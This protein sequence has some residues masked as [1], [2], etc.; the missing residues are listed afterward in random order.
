MIICDPQD[1]SAVGE[2]PRMS[3]LDARSALG[4]AESARRTMI[5]LSAQ[6]RA[7]ILE[8]VA[9]R[10]VDNAETRAV[11]IAR[12]GV[13][14]ITEARLEVSRAINTL[15]LSSHA[16]LQMTGET[17][18]FQSHPNGV[19]RQGWWTPEPIGIVVAITPF[20]DPL[21]LV[22][23]KLGPAIAAGCPVVLK[24]HEATPLSAIALADDLRRAGLP[25]GALEIV[26]G[27]GATVGPPLVTDSRTALISFTGGLDTGRRIANSAGLTRMAMELGS[28][29][30]TIILA[31]AD[32]DVA[33]KAC[34][35][36]MISTAGQN[37]LHVQ[38][39]VCARE[40]A[41]TF[42]DRIAAGLESVRLGPK[43][44]ETT[45]MGCLISD[46]A[47]IRISQMVD[48]AIGNGARCLTGGIRDGTWMHPVLLDNV[49]ANDPLRRDE[50]FGPVAV[51]IEVDCFDE[52]IAISNETPFG[53]QAAIFTSNLANAH[54]AVRQLD[55]GAVL[56][57]E[58]TDYRLD[59]MPFGG[60]RHSGI[61]REG[62]ASAIASMSEPKVACFT[63]VAMA[64]GADNSLRRHS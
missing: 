29:C 26:T 56:V 51:L 62:V 30:P 43:C 63:N 23:H 64:K 36:G 22:A 10:L 50:V 54:A 42:R 55:A 9:S 25:K 46:A 1:G 11:L 15:R 44:D 17:I 7:S 48:N 37:C 8:S 41:D 61:G 13:K 34:L 24:P 4:R 33:A 45:Q 59:A 27:E 60:T 52:A 21:N 57:N 47:G 38:R 32:L 58:S 31:D 40:I 12:E 14:T 28:N 49:K 39:I 6:E 5:E 2:V 20:N 53:L 18:P 3:M 19:H 16:A 35:S